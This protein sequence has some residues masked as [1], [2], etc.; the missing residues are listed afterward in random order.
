MKIREIWQ[1][2]FCNVCL[3]I[4]WLSVATSVQSPQ[5]IRIRPQGNPFVSSLDAIVYDTYPDIP[6]LIYIHIDLY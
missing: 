3:Q 6:T 2:F 1:P 4:N 5:A